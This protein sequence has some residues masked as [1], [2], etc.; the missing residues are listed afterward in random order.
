MWLEMQTH[1]NTQ[2]PCDILTINTDY[3]SLD[4]NFYKAGWQIEVQVYNWKMKITWESD[5]CMLID[6]ILSK[7]QYVI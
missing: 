7:S 5:H 2:C 3:N 6:I 4:F 1:Q